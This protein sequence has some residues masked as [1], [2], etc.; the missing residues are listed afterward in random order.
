MSSLVALLLIVVILLALVAVALRAGSGGP[1]RAELVPAD[2]GDPVPL[3]R[4]LVVGRLDADL[5]I[6][7]PTVSAIH[8]EL[9]RERGRWTVHDR[10]SRNGTFVNQS[11]VDHR[12]LADGD[13]IQFARDGPIYV[14]RAAPAADRA[15]P[16]LRR[17][18]R[19]PPGADSVTGQAV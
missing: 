19:S 4:R 6:L 12:A 8:A 7:E 10:R 5:V 2:G 11:R 16:R 15:R 9:R 13:Q 3:R 1:G 17:P 18:G 14:F